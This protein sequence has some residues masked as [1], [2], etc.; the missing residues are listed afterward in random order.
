MVSGWWLVV[1]IGWCFFVGIVEGVYVCVV[2]GGV[3]L[4]LFDS[5]CSFNFGS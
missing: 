2:G 4:S 3:F 5:L 1:V